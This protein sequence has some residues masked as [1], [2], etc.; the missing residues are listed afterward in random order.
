MTLPLGTTLVLENEGE[1]WFPLASAQAIRGTIL[2]IIRN[3]AA[4]EP[5]YLVH[6]E[7]P[8]EVQDC[9][10]ATPSGL[11]LVR[12][13]YAVIRSRWTGVAVGSESRVSCFVQLV[14]LES[15]LPSTAEECAALPLRIWASCSVTA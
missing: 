15:A 12:Y 2:G 7:S 13:E 4:S 14:P 1:G 11:L 9:S 10:S 6:L 3:E 5:F 8:L